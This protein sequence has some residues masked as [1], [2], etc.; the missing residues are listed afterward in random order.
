MPAKRQL[1][2]AVRSGR[3]GFHGLEFWEVEHVHCEMFAMAVQGLC[4][5]FELVAQSSGSA[6]LLPAAAARGAPLPSLLQCL[7]GVAAYALIRVHCHGP[8]LRFFL[9][10]SR[11]CAP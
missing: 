4:R 5:T 3:T 6:Q 2:S 9:C 7:P 1:E 8:G 10:R 11:S